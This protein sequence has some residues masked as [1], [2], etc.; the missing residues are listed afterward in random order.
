MNY[1]CGCGIDDL[2]INAQAIVR[3][4]PLDESKSLPENHD[5]IGMSQFLDCFSE[6]EIISILKRAAPRG[7]S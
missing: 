2:A 5:A 4:A 1:F 6:K 7:N 3:F